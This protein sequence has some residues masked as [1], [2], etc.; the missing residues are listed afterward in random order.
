MLLTSLKTKRALCYHCG[1]SLVRNQNECLLPLF[2]GMYRRCSLSKL[3][4]FTGG[5]RANELVYSLLKFGFLNL[6]CFWSDLKPVYSISE[7]GPLEKHSRQ[8]W[9]CGV[10]RKQNRS[11]KLPLLVP[12]PSFSAPSDSF[13]TVGVSSVLRLCFCNNV[14]FFL[15]GVVSPTL[16]PHKPGELVYFRSVFLPLATGSGY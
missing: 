6:R 10:L 7:H 4:E 14:F 16:N 8:Q 9:S 5:N 15:A 11:G 3:A 2:A 12:F 1:N 13:I